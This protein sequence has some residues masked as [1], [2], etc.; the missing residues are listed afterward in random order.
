MPRLNRRITVSALAGDANG[1]TI[2]TANSVGGLAVPQR[3]VSQIWIRQ[4]DNVAIDWRGAQQGSLA[5]AKLTVPGGE[6]GLIAGISRPQDVELFLP[7]GQ[8]T[9]VEVQVAIDYG[10]AME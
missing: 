8:A 4:L 1:T 3:Y 2:S 7:T 6:A 5:N 9:P 10:E